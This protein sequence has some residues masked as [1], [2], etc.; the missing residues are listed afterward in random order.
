M[1][2]CLTNYYSCLG[3]LEY[4]RNCL[5]LHVDQRLGVLTLPILSPPLQ[6]FCIQCLGLYYRNLN[7]P[8]Q[9]QGLLIPCFQMA[10][11]I[12]Y[13]LRLFQQEILYVP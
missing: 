12:L 8:N 10:L 7:V 13:P 2:G 11:L 5:S 3:G 4:A 1:E 6:L 9:A